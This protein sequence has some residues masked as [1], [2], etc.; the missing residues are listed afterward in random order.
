MYPGPEPLRMSSYTL[1]C[2][3]PSSLQGIAKK[4]FLN[5]TNRRVVNEKCCLPFQQTKDVAAIKPSHY[6]PPAG[7][8]QGNSGWRQMGCPLPSPK[9]LQ[10]PPAVHPEGIQDGKKAGYLV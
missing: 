3:S 2:I 5:V 7:E 8:P 6:S 9:P 1:R 10:Q 4:L